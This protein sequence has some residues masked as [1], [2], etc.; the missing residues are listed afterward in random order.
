MP[1]HAA[2][3]RFGIEWLAAEFLPEKV[4][5]RGHGEAINEMPAVLMG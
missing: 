2:T 4:G 1:V 3:P 5:V